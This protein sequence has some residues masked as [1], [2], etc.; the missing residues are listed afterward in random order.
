MLS[1]LFTVAGALALLWLANTVLGIV[2]S[3]STITANI[4]AIHE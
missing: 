4:L 1:T 2:S 3:L